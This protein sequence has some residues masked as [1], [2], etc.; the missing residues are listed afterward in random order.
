MQILTIRELQWLIGQQVPPCISL[1]MPTHRH[2]PETGQ[3][4]IRYRNLLTT[5]AGLLREKYRE[6]DV[7]RLLEPAEKLS[8]TEFWRYQEDGL[9]VFCTPETCIHYRLPVNVPEMVVVADTFHTKPLVGFLNSNHH[10][11]V[12]SLSR[13][14][15]ALY[16]GTPHRLGRIDLASVVPEFRDL[17]SE[18]KAATFLSVTGEG[19]IGQPPDRHGRAPEDKLGKKELTKYFRA[20]DH[21]LWSVLRDEHA[22]LVLAAVSYY[23][24]LFLAASRYPYILPEGIEGNVERWSVDELRNAAW[25]L[26]SAYEANI[27]REISAQYA[28]AFSSGRASNVLSDIARAAAHGRVGVLLHETGRTLWGQ[29]DA[30]TGEVNVHSQQQQHDTRDADIIDDLCELVLLKGGEVIEISSGPLL[31]DSPVGAIYRY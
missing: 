1:Y 23:H 13:K 18:S 15:I 2:F 30:E 5:A 6:R 14:E 20:I 22:P 9:A 31:Q 16:E 28:H 21:A 11:F 26:V 27:E 4:P 24:S 29:M 17:V 19:D 7:G 3:D 12:L 8:T 10:Y 25:P